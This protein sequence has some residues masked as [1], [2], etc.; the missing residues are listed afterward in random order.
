MVS[1]IRVPGRNRDFFLPPKCNGTP[2]MNFKQ[3]MTSSELSFQKI[4]P[5]A[6]RRVTS[7][8]ARTAAKSPV[9]RLPH[10]SRQD[11]MVAWLRG[12]MEG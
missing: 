2:L 4:P 3:V 12:T 11:M 6:G 9:K 8:K 10:P 1:P 7:K 5:A